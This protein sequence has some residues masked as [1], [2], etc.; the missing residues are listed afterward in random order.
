MARN[1]PS[2]SMSEIGTLSEE[3]SFRVTTHLHSPKALC[4]QEGSLLHTLSCVPVVRGVWPCIRS[5][6]RRIRPP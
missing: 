3:G 4:S 1:L 5:Y 2:R 6:R